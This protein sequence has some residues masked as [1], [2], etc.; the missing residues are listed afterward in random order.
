MWS[1]ILGKINKTNVNLPKGTMKMDVAT[2]LLTSLVNFINSFCNNFYE[3]ESTPKYPEA[4]CK[5]HYQRE[6]S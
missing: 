5:D 1:S 4:E 3:F 6:G 2:N